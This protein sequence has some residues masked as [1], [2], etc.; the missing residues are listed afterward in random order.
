[1]S[2]KAFGKNQIFKINKDL[3]VGD[4]IIPK[5]SRAII[6]KGGKNPVVEFIVGSSVHA[7]ASSVDSL[8]EILVEAEC[9][10]DASLVGFEVKKAFFGRGQETNEI[11]LDLYL[12]KKLVATGEN[13]G[14]GGCN[15]LRVYDNDAN[16]RI[17]TFLDRTAA[18]QK[19]KTRFQVEES[20][21]TFLAIYFNSGLLD[22]L[23]GITC[24]V[25]NL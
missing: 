24:G 12:D 5:D 13:D 15:F 7:I 19:T 6:S 8:K 10:R 18:R 17:K 23:Y 11:Y 3:Q 21:V 14:R 22:W 20:F 4:V 25:K 1:M 9:I 2:S 16:A